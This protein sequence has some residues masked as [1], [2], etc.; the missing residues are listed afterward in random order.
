MHLHQGHLLTPAMHVEVS[1]CTCTCPCPLCL[2][3]CLHK[4]NRFV[5]GSNIVV[6]GGV[7]ARL[8]TE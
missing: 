1:Q 6:D 5:T 4:S 2:F 3:L 8:G 7:L